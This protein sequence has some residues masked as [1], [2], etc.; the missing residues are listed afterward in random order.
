MKKAAVLFLLSFLIACGGG[1]GGGDSSPP[2]SSTPTDTPTSSISHA[3]VISTLQYSPDTALQN[4]D[5][6]AVAITAIVN[7]TDQGGDASVVTVKKYDS[8][9]ALLNTTSY[10]IQS[11]SGLVSR[12]I[13]LHGTISTADVGDFTLAIYITDAGGGISSTFAGVFSVTAVPEAK[14]EIISVTNTTASFLS[15]SLMITVKN[16]GTAIGYNAGCNA[17]ALNAAGAIV[18]TATAFFASLENI[19][20]GQ[21]AISEAVFF[22][23]NSHAEY[24]TLE[25]DC[26]WLTRH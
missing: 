16:T 20:V 18:D 1:G 10:D 9:Y 22:H 24:A 13:R 14:I 11:T 23:L 8:R 3:P 4:Q 26:S 5:G 12:T 17:N 6:G 25:Y 7:F 21:S 2:A 15:P 19:N